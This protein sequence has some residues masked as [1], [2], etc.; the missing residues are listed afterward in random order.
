[1]APGACCQYRSEA[2]RDASFAWIDAHAE[3]QWPVPSDS[4]TVPTSFGPTF[5][6]ISGPAAGFPLVLLPGA[7]TSSL[8]WSPNIAALSAAFRTFAVDRVGDF[9]KSLCTRRPRTLDDLVCWV[10]EFLDALDLRREVHLLGISYGASLAAEVALQ[11]PSRVRRL[12]LIAPGAIVLPVTSGLMFRLI[13]AAIARR[14]GLDSLLRWLLQDAARKDPQWMEAVLDQYRLHMRSVLRMVPM[15]RVW[16]DTDWGLLRVPTLF[17]V[18]EH[19]KIYSPTKALSRLK[20][21]APG[22]TAQLVPGAGHDLTFVAAAAVNRDILD[23][24]NEDTPDS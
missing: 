11:R 10:A 4:R 24:L 8:M 13:V 18:G 19:E 15:P 1:M 16:S 7:A 5:V 23:F 21:V 12:V 22:V 3:R 2:A 14:R 9:G 17:L 20:R 6:R